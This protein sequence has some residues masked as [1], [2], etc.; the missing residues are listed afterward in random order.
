M[1]W[2][3]IRFHAPLASFGGETI[4]VHGVIRDFPAQSM[5]TGLCSPTPW[6]G[7]VLCG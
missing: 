3:Q 4:D 7:P 5:L 1:R 6:V 2:L